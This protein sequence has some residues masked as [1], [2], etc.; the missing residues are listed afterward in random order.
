MYELTYQDNEVAIKF[1]KKVNEKRQQTYLYGDKASN[2]KPYNPLV[3]RALRKGE[4][5]LEKC[6]AVRELFKEQGEELS[7]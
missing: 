4:R 3:Y 1:W 5:E 6:L 7:S 2:T